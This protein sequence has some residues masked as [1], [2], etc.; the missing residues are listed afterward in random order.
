MQ[1]KLKHEPQ[2]DLFKM[3]LKEMVSLKHSLI[4]LSHKIDWKLIEDEF[5]QYYSTEG[6]PSVPTRTMV[7]LLMLKSMFNEADE[8]LIPRWVENP[9]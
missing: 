8:E 3:P 9:Y 1:G 2:L 7:G 6:R 4:I 5:Q